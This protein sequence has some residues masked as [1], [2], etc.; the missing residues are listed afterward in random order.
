MLLEVFLN[1][2]P[3]PNAPQP[4]GGNGVGGGSGEA[5]G[6]PDGT[7]TGHGSGGEPDVGTPQ[8]DPDPGKDPGGNDLWGLAHRKREKNDVA[9]WD[10][11]IEAS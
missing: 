10:C 7:G 1:N 11:Q 8:G 9:L 6:N 5:G 4:L 2:N 3:D